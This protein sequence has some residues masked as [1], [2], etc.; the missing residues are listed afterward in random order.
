MHWHGL[1]DAYYRCR[2]I[3]SGRVS[4]VNLTTKTNEIEFPFGFAVGL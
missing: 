1:V 4:H 3:S 2:A